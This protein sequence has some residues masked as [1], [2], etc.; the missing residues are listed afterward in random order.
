M[1][2]G[3]P[4]ESRLDRIRH[5]EEVHY[6]SLCRIA[7]RYTLARAPREPDHDYMED[8]R[9][10]QQLDGIEGGFSFLHL[11]EL[12]FKARLPWRPQ[13]IGSCV[14]SASMRVVAMRMLAEVFLFGDPEQLFGDR[15]EG[16]KSLASFAPY[17]YR[18]GRRLAGINGMGDGSLC[19][20]QIRGLMQFGI[21]PC[22]TPGIISESF[23]EPQNAR[24]YREW[25]ANNV[26]MDQFVDSAKKFPL[27]ESTKTLGAAESKD[28][29]TVGLKPELICSAWA[30]KPDRP[31]PTWRLRDGSQV[32]I[33]T[34]DRSATWQHAMSRVAY[35]QVA[36]QW[37]C[38]I[39]NSWG[40]SHKNGAWFAIPAE[41]DDQWIKQ[42]EVQTIGEIDM[43]DN[44]PLWGEIE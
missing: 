10:R 4:D 38:I 39:L 15:L 1:G 34:R 40:D 25:G 11:E 27:V 37:Y 42:A 2:W 5:Y 3:P 26:L 31:H 12:V 28:N 43:S 44:P 21:L 29:L 20:P 17:H 33:Y 41:L 30:F 14:A 7:P 19:L 13:I 8:I 32:W 35:V 24:L 22:H 6:E 36:G 23:P 16:T 9:H 18:A